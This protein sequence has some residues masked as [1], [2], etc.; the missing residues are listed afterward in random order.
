MNPL[1]ILFKFLF[2][3]FFARREDA[4]R[5][6]AEEER[7][8][9]FVNETEAKWE[10]EDAADPL[11]VLAKPWERERNAGGATTRH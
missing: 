7:V 2:G 11:I 4:R 1:A 9:R 10:A 8:R 6:R 3:L 5:R